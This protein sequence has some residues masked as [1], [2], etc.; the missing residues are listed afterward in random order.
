MEP[1]LRTAAHLQDILQELQAREPIFHQPQFGRSRRDFENMT[2]EEFW[3]TGASGARYSREYV[4]NVLETR[5]PDPN[6][7]SWVTSEF[8]C[9]EIAADNYLLTYTLA[10]GTRVTRRATLWRR[11]GEGW[12]ILY[13]QGT[14]VTDGQ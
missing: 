14:T 11:T 6:E 3:E 4:L 10:Q 7:S 8:Q 2:H 13:H 12:K 5:P 9:R 1:D